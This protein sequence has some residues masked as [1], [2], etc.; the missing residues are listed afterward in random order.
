MNIFCDTS[1][2]LAAAKSSAG[3][4][5]AFFVCGLM[6]ADTNYLMGGTGQQRPERGHLLARI[7]AVKVAA[8]GPIL[9]AGMTGGGKAFRA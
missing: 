3:A 7:D 1:V 6:I 2:L 9:I 4:S 8:G 5:R